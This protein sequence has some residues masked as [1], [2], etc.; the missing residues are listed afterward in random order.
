MRTKESD[1]DKSKNE[2]RESEMEIEESKKRIRVSENKG[3][4]WRAGN[5]F[6]VNYTNR[7]TTFRL[8]L[9]DFGRKFY[10]HDRTSIAYSLFMDES[11]RTRAKEILESCV[12]DY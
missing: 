12:R 11:E 1:L 10:V 7:G 6:Y 4:V 5:E 2:I 3:L 8:N 9:E